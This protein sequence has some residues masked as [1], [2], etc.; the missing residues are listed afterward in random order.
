MTGSILVPR[1]RLPFGQHKDHGL[2]VTL[3]ML[4]VKSDKSDW[5]WSQSIVFTNP[6]KSECRWSWPEVAILGADQ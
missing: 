3:R 6:S 5:S 1:G 4:R 2:P